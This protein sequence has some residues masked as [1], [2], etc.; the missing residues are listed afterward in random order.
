[1]IQL[2]RTVDKY[3][4][5]IL[6]AIF[7]IFSK[8]NAKV[9]EHVSAILIIKLWAVGESI[10]TLPMI[11]LLKKRYP[12]ARIDVLTRRRNKDVYT[13]NKDISRIFALGEFHL[14]LFRKYDL[15]FDCEPYLNLSAILSFFVAK[16][17]VGFDHGIRS[18]IYNKKVN[19]NDKQ[20][21]VQ[22]YVDL[23]S[24]FDIIEKPNRLVHLS[25]PLSI[26]RKVLEFFSKNK[27]TKNDF[28]VGFC[29]GSAESGQGRKWPIDKFAFLADTLVEKNHAK[30]ILTGTKSEH[31]LNEKMISL[32]KEKNKKN[33][34][35]FAGLTN[36][37]ELFAL[38]E[39]CNLFI[40]NDT[41]TMH[42]AAA[43]NVKTIGLFGP[44]TP[45]RFGPFGKGNGFVYK[46]T[47]SEPCINV[48]KG[49]IPDCKN[50]FHMEN[51]SVGDVLK[52]IRKVLQKRK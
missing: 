39:F 37:K 9:P 33:I 10:L 45:V 38:V 26:K 48:H 22:T 25:Y 31:E 44:N 50:H 52:E 15:S 30:I 46:P 18:R 7:G 41:G 1:M 16:V 21:V 29:V 40:S 27:I 23:L 13:D 47:L 43:Q 36:L 11:H 6:C 51:I 14:N 19:Y 34:F 8:K 20:H 42:V 35:N 4:G 3:V 24:D 2:E 17:R 12:N 32:V 28:L 49:I 5:N